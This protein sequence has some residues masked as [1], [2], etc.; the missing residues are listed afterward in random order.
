MTNAAFQSTVNIDYA[1]GVIGEIFRDDPWRAQRVWVNSNGAEP[2]QIGYAFTQNNQTGVASVGGALGTA[3]ATFT[4][5]MAVNAFTGYVGA[6][7]GTIGSNVLTVSA[8]STGGLFVGMTFTAGGVTY[9]I[10]GLGTGTGGTGTYFLNAVGAAASASLT[11]SGGWLNV[12]A[13]ATGALAVNDALTATGL[14]GTAHIL[15]SSTAGTGGTGTGSTGTYGVD[16]AQTVSSTNT[17]A[18]AAQGPG[19]V[20]AGILANPKDYASIGD[21]SGTLDPVTTIPDNSF[22]ELLISG[23]I[24]VSLPGPFNIGDLVQWNNTT[25]ALSTVAPGA[26]ATSGNTL[27]PNAYVFGYSSIGNGL[28][29]IHL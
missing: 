28:A 3:A 12:T 29:A 24:V 25:G 2:N 4:A 1:F 6:S 9:T 21:S 13:V 11:G 15:S 5:S 17:F 27:I 19:T 18:S 20:F 14:T 22:G 7:S 16:T 8:V 23:T 26:S 10:T